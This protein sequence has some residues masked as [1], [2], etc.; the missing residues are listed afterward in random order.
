MSSLIDT[1]KIVMRPVTV[2]FMEMHDPKGLPVSLPA[3]ISDYYSTQ[4]LLMNTRN[5]IMVLEKNIFGL[6]EW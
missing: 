5:F 6:T 4:F 1:S 3:H 2:T